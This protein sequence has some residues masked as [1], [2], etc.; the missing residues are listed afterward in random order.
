MQHS[1]SSLRIVLGLGGRRVIP[2]LPDGLENLGVGCPRGQYDTLKRA[3]SGTQWVGVH[4]TLAVHLVVSLHLLLF[5]CE[6]TLCGV[7]DSKTCTFQHEL[8]SIDIFCQIRS[9]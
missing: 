2:K 1:T 7:T 8:I 6:N 9:L 5:K 3:E 4:C